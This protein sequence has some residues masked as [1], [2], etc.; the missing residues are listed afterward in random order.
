MAHRRSTMPLMRVMLLHWEM[1]N[2]HSASHLSCRRMCRACGDS[3]CPAAPAACRSEPGSAPDDYFVCFFSAACISSHGRGVVTV[4]VKIFA[5]Q[6]IGRGGAQVHPAV[7]RPYP[8]RIPEGDAGVDAVFVR[9]PAEAL[10][11]F[12]GF[13]YIKLIRSRKIQSMYFSIFR[14][15]NHRQDYKSQR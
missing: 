8:R 15:K 12:K 4:E 7:L 3:A 13:H 1:M 11:A 6:L 14:H 9:V 10:P 5:P 2:E